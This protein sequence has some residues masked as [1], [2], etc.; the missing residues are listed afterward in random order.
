MAQADIDVNY[1]KLGHSEKYCKIKVRIEGWW[2][3]ELCHDLAI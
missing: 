1:L 3:R 2:A